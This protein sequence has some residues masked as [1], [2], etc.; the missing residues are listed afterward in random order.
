MIAL[1]AYFDSSGKVADDYLTLAAFAG[2]EEMWDKFETDWSKILE[3]HT[4]QAKYVHM[5]EIAHQRGGFDREHGWNEQNA[6]GLATSCL[7]Y[8]SS[9]DKKRFRMFYC[10]VDLVAWRR[11]RAETYALPSPI[12]LCNEFCSQGVLMW[13]VGFYPDVVNLSADTI[14]Y[15]FDNGEEFKGPFENKWKKE[16]RQSKQ[17]RVWSIWK[18]IEQVSSVDMKNVPGVQAADILAWAVNRENTVA[19]GKAGKH[20]RHVMQQVIPTSYVVWDEAKMRK[21]FKPLVHLR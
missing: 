4:P 8:M 1:R 14:R 2:N 16:K 5:R 9:L 18:L 10:A 3:E 20:L 11:L 7:S 12:D 19:E 13:Y 6:F 15:F 21:H 17:T